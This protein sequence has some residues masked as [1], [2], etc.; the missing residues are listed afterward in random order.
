MTSDTTD[1][2]APLNRRGLIPVWAPLLVMAAVVLTGIVL[3]GV[4]T[5]YIVLFA[6]SAVV[7]TALVELRGLFLTVVLLPAYWFFGITGAGLAGDTPTSAGSSLRTTL[8][9]AA[10]PAIEKFLWLAGTFV[11][12]VIIAVVRQRIDAAVL[13]SQHRRERSR[14]RQMSDAEQ[15]NQRL[16]ARVRDYDRTSDRARNNR[17]D[18]PDRNAQTTR[19]YRT[20]SDAT[21][22]R[23]ERPAG[24]YPRYSASFDEN[25]PPATRREETEKSDS[26]ETRTRTA[27]E[28]REASRRRRSRS[29]DR[30]LDMD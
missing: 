8:I 10:Y 13:Q 26:T 2:S 25:R 22:A 9:T 27:A 11:I 16:N 28:L 20:S 6:V 18:R 14:R 4:G 19:P 12:C 17:A 24:D 3:G 29:Q 1:E 21:D 30:P 15:N 7:C 23:E 5:A